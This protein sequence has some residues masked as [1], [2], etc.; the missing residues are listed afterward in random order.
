MT[1]PAQSGKRPI[2]LE[3]YKRP[4]IL[5]AWDRFTCW[6][7]GH[8]TQIGTLYGGTKLFCIRCWREVEEPKP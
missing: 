7:F 4:L 8:D 6:I 2:K 1:Q 3:P 5:A